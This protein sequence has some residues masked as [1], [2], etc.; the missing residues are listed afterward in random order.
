MQQ[1]GLHLGPER[2]ETPGQPEFGT[3]FERSIEEGL[4]HV[5]GESGLQ[6]VLSLYPLGQISTDP[7]MLHKILRDVF[8]ENGAAVIERE[9][10]TRLLANIGNETAPKAGHGGPWRAAPSPKGKAS[11]QVS[12]REK[13]VLLKFLA[14][15]SL[16]RGGSGNSRLELSP[17]DLTAARFAH[18]FKKGS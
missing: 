17:I 2:R 7:V 8:N 16:P 5:L 4:R 11:P 1:Q 13:D 10:A 14:L 15:K 18:A 9:V 3:A 12:K 6:L